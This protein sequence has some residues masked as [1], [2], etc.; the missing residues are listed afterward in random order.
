[1]FFFLMMLTAVLL[2]SGCQK[3][4]DEELGVKL[5]FEVVEGKEIKKLI[6]I[7]KKAD[8]QIAEIYEFQSKEVLIKV[9]IDKEF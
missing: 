8:I 2:C 9:V 6:R 7:S 3:S 1:M 5:R 4:I